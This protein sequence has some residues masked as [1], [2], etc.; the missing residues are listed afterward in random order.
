M[1]LASS[2]YGTFFALNIFLIP[3]RDSTSPLP[4]PQGEGVIATFWRTH[5]HHT[6]PEFLTFE[7]GSQVEILPSPRR[8]GSLVHTISEQITLSLRRGLG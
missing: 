1:S 4:S 3:L 5:Q 6:S 2:L 7:L 8:R